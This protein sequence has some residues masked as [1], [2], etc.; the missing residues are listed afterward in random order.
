VWP[1]WPCSYPLAAR[2]IHEAGSRFADVLCL[3]VSCITNDVPQVQRHGQPGELRAATLARARPLPLK[4]GEFQFAMSIQYRVHEEQRAS[5]WIVEQA[6][7]A[8]ALFDRAGREL[9]VYHWHPEW[10]GLRPEAHLHLAAALLEADYKRT[11][12]QQHLPTG[13]VGMEDV[14]GMLIQELGVPPNRN[15]WHDTL[16]LTKLQMNEICTQNVAESTR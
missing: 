14:L 11:F 15:D 7:Y 12:A 6:S 1:A 2:T 10:A 4:G 3:A 16:A 9:L 8:Y 13:R 5:G